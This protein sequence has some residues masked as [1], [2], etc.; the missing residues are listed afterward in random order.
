[1]FTNRPRQ[2][3]E[4]RRPNSWPVPT[5]AHLSPFDNDVDG[6]D[7]R[8][9]LEEVGER[10]TPYG[11]KRS[12]TQVV[13]VTDGQRGVERCGDRVPSGSL[14]GEIQPVNRGNL[15]G[16]GWE[17]VAAIVSERC[18]NQSK[19]VEECK[20]MVD[21]LKKRYKLERHNMSTG[22]ISTS[23]WPWFKRMGQIVGNSLSLKIAAEEVKGV[24]PAGNS[25]GQWKRYGAAIASCG[26]QLIGMKSKAMS[27]LRWRRVV[28]KINGVAL[29]RYD[30]C[31]IDP[32]ACS[33][34]VSDEEK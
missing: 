34:N 25:L 17:E 16:R 1:M 21:N 13:G 6:N 23:H 26:G 9:D 30:N 31:N 14:H 20:N 19:S 5:R 24:G 15:R 11:G 8:K 7:E 18:E 33:L 4:S 27:N 29:T 12:K 2:I 10:T 32:K 22:Y 28:L 3:C